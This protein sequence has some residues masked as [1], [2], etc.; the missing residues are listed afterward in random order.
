MR[1]SAVRSG[2]RD[3]RGRV[4]R[5]GV[6]GPSTVCRLLPASWYFWAGL[7]RCHRS[8]FHG[9]DPQIHAEDLLDGLTQILRVVTTAE[10]RCRTLVLETERERRAV[11][12]ERRRIGAHIH[13]GHLAN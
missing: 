11:E 2:F 9:Q 8:I 6:G 13:P 10:V 3:R 5:S 12:A 4:Y 1:R 7:T